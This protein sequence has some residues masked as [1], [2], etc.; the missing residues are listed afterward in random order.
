MNNLFDPNSPL[1][2]AFNDIFGQA[3]D[4]KPQA[5]APVSNTTSLPAVARIGV[6]RQVTSTAKPR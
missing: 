2:S 3:T 4:A 6:A 5:P 1:G